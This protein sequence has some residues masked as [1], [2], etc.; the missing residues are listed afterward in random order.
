MHCRIKLRSILYIFFNFQHPCFNVFY[1][2]VWMWLFANLTLKWE[3]SNAFF[4]LRK[5]VTLTLTPPQKLINVLQFIN[6]LCWEYL[7][8]VIIQLY[9]RIKWHSDLHNKFTLLISQH[10]LHMS[11]SKNK[12]KPKSCQVHFTL[13]RIKPNKTTW[14]P[15]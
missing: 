14:L 15:T 1:I 9:G 4:L 2:W 8:C 12:C 3:N 11:Q 6:P 7:K 13:W 10:C 5:T